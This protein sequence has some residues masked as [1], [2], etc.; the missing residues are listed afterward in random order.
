M[1][2]T[3]YVAVRKREKRA[4]P[5]CEKMGVSTAPVPAAI[6]EKGILVDSL[7]VDTIIKKYRKRRS[8]DN[9]AS[10]PPDPCL[11]CWSDHHNAGAGGASRVAR[12]ESP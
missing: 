10:S 1:P 7:V 2:V 3:F 12:T 8:L 11:G 5:R 6:V 9:P 4:C